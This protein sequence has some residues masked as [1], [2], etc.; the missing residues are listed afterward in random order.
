MKKRI[1]F[2]IVG[3]LI[4]CN[5]QSQENNVLANV[6]WITGTWENKTEI[7]SIYERWEK[8]SD[9]ELAG[10][11]YIIKDKDTIVFET[12]RLVYE[13][14]K[15]YYIPIVEGGNDGKPVR[16]TSRLISEDKLEFEN[17]EHDFPQVISYIRT[18]NKSLIAEISGIVEGKEEKESY[19]MTKIK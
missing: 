15:V 18:G 12:I 6:E 11:S 2:I 13:N 5:L 14:E 19:P 8:I 10:K 7:G 16:F 3:L 17:S 1:M 4:F 9:T